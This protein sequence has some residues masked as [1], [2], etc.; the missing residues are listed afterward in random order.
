MKPAFNQAALGESIRLRAVGL[1]DFT[2][3]KTVD[4]AS[5]TGNQDPTRSISPMLKRIVHSPTV[6]AGERRLFVVR[7][8]L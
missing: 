5:R 8:V 2:G 7:N 1:P 6:C 3:G 4:E